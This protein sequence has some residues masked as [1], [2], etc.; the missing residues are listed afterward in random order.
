MGSDGTEASVACGEPKVESPAVGFEGG[1]AKST[2]IHQPM[3]GGLER[4][5][6]LQKQVGDLRVAIQYPLAALQPKP[7]SPHP[8]LTF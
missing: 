8:I 4:Q 2:P 7:P 6:N 1:S 3:S 5:T